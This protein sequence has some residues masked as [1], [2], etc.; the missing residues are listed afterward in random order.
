MWW[1]DNVLIPELAENVL[2]SQIGLCACTW[3]RRGIF[4]FSGT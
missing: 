2:T 1:I 3:R 4:T